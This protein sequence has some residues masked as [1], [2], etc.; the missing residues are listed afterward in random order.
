MLM[1]RHVKFHF[2]S[3]LQTYGSNKS[4][5]TTSF[6]GIRKSMAVLKCCT[7]RPNKFGFL[8]SFSSTTGMGT[9]KWHW[10]QKPRSDIPVKFSGNHQRFIKALARWTLNISPT[11]N[12]VASWSLEVGRTMVRKLIW[13]ISIRFVEQSA[14][15]WSTNNKLNIFSRFLDQTSFKSGSIYLSSTYQLNGM[16]L[17]SQQVVMRNII[18]AAPSHSLISHSS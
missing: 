5:T 17:K 16:F 13:N 15:N 6:A 18:H 4:G 9:T 11:M 14:W 12:K 2:R 7:F 8:M 1:N 10:W 3:W